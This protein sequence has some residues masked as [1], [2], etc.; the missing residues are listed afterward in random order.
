VCCAGYKKEGYGGDY[1][2]YKEKDLH[3][4]EGYYSPDNMGYPRDDYYG[5][6]DV[7][8]TNPNKWPANWQG[9]K[10]LLCVNPYSGVRLHSLQ[11]WLDLVASPACLPPHLCL[12]QSP[13]LL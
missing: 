1:D 10:G 4:D 11:Q 3:S 6:G 12:R 8:C 13:C 2:Y 5:D 7:D 9:D